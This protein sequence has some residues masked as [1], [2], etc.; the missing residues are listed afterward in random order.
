MSIPKALAN[1]RVPSMLSS[2]LVYTNLRYFCRKLQSPGSGF[3]RG[4]ASRLNWNLEMLVFKE[5][6]IKTSK[7]REKNQI[8]P[9]MQR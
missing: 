9:H 2:V 6:Q 5:R 3:H 4:S 8:S 1:Q 7:S